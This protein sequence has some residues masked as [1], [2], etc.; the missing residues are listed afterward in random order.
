MIEYKLTT[1]KKNGRDYTD[2]VVVINGHDFI[3]KPAPFYSKKASNYFNYLL[4]QV[5][6]V[7]EEE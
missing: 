1:T 7:K 2:L 4:E 6:I 3:M 5:S